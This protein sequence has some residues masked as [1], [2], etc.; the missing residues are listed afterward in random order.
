MKSAT[1]RKSRW[2]LMTETTPSGKSL[3][4]CSSCG[5]VSVGPDKTCTAGCHVTEDQTP[6]RAR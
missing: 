5:R 3:F 1:K 6:E 2:E 4:K